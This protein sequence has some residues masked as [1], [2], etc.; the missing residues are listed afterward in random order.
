MLVKA[1]IR[2]LLWQAW[3]GVTQGLVHRVEKDKVMLIRRIIAMN[4]WRRGVSQIG[5]VTRNKLTKILR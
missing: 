5:G 1:C 4:M 3:Q 2:G